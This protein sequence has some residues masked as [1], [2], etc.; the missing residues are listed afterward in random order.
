[1]IQRVHGIYSYPGVLLRVYGGQ[2][3]ECR[4]HHSQQQQLLQWFEAV[5]ESVDRR[6][7]KINLQ[8]ALPSQLK[9]RGIRRSACMRRKQLVTSWLHQLFGTACSIIAA[10]SFLPNIVDFR[11]NSDGENVVFRSIV[12]LLHQQQQQ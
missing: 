2:M 10:W 6:A 1:M 3:R 7:V 4:P 11:S 8:V 5:Q 12:T 9:E